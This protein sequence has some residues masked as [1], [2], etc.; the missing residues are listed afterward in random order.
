MLL[1]E[2]AFLAVWSIDVANNRRANRGTVSLVRAHAGC[3]GRALVWASEVSA[4]SLG[5]SR[6]CARRK[7]SNSG[8][9]GTWWERQ[10]LS[11]ATLR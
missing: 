9:L 5:G 10:G 11:C 8:C 3:D 4:V 7:L 1:V 2:W 6:T